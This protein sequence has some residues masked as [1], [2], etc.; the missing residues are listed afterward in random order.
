[1]FTGFKEGMSLADDASIMNK[2]ATQDLRAV[3]IWPTIERVLNS[4][5]PAPS[6]LAKE[7]EK[8]V[9]KWV[10][11]G[12]SRY[13]KEGPK[14]P[15][16][17][18]L[19]AAWTGMGEAVLDPVL[20][21]LIGEL[22]SLQ[23]PNNG[24]N[25]QGSSYGSGWYGYVYKGLQPVLGETVGS[26]A[27]PRLLRRRRTG[28]LPQHRCGR[29]SRAQPKASQKSA[30]PRRS[31]NGGPKRCGSASCRTCSK[32]PNRRTASSR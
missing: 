4:P 12:S 27:Q 18:I 19:D 9:M 23:G 22:K 14:A 31:R 20:G 15:G 29:P 26:A 10:K 28:S 32:N 5:G 6:A 2:A 25:S 3:Q 11:S 24:E 7:A 1:M 8:T 17:A 21:E 13:G 16:A 30:G